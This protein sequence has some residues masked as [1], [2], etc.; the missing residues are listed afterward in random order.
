ML[1]VSL[2]TA[3]GLLMRKPLASPCRSARWYQ[4][5]ARPSG[6]D[7]LGAETSPAGRFDLGRTSPTINP[8]VKG[9]IAHVQV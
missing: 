5:T 9:P 2:E 1:P 3:T 7:P 4:A 8:H 6:S